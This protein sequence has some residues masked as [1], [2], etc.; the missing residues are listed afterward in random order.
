MNHDTHRTLGKQSAVIAFVAIVILILMSALGALLV[1]KIQARTSQLEVLADQQIQLWQSIQK[2]LTYVPNERY[3]KISDYSVHRRIQNN[4]ARMLNEALNNE[5]RIAELASKPSNML[6]WRNFS[7]TRNSLVVH[8]NADER[9]KNYVE[10]FT[11]YSVDTLKLGIS[12]W[13]N[14]IQISLRTE[15]YLSP[16]RQLKTEIRNIVNQAYARSTIVALYANLLLLLGIFI[17]WKNILAP[18]YDALVKSNADLRQTKQTLASLSN[19]F[20]TAFFAIKE[21][22]CIVNKHGAIKVYNEAFGKKFIT[23]KKQNFRLESVLS[24]IS[25]ETF[26]SKLPENSTTSEQLHYLNGTTT[27]LSTGESVTWQRS[28]AGV[29][30]W[31]LMAIDRTELLFKADEAAHKERLHTLGRVSGEIAHDFNNILASIMARVEF[32]LLNNKQD[33]E[34]GKNRAE[35]LELVV[36]TCNRAASL[37]A[38]LLHFAKRQPLQSNIV[39]CESVAEKINAEFLLQTD[40]IKLEIQ[41]EENC[42]TV[43]DEYALVTAIENLIQNSIESIGEEQG[44]IVVT[45]KKVTQLKSQENL[46]KIKITV[47]DTGPGFSEGTISNAVEPFFSTKYEKNG[48]GLGLSMV[49]GLVQQSGGEMLISNNDKGAVIN[50]FFPAHE[51][52]NAVQLP[53]TQADENGGSSIDTILSQL[54]VERD[55]GVWLKRKH[56]VL[57]EDNAE[58]SNILERLLCQFGFTVDPISTCKEGTGLIEKSVSIDLAIC[59]W[60]LEEST[61]DVFIKELLMS[62]HSTKVILMTGNATPEITEFSNKHSIDLLQKPVSV[63]KLINALGLSIQ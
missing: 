60:Q 27:S 9:L 23:K 12:T 16:L 4:V 35:Q 30:T 6:L 5:K 54:P 61:S 34:D 44:S 17:I 10:A 63:K 20:S 41:C 22:A 2:S 45:F 19:Q 38:R 1:L 28:I 48:T 51:A 39:N 37:I 53:W 52:P 58:L 59:D 40:K 43:I 13:D 42:H 49:H 62:S 8:A 25:D 33:T 56:C 14:D 15:E 18:A 29:D 47:A 32:L 50:M 55:D 46:E 31:L 24:Q 3:A 57:L 36:D 26:Q 11:Q 7:A 21:P